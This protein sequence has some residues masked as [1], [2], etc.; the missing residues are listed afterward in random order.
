MFLV[1]LNLCDLLFL[2]KVSVYFGE[3]KKK[4]M[5]R[6]KIYVWEFV[7]IFWINMVREIDVN[8][9]KWMII[10]REF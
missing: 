7:L 4:I 6:L 10:F 1:W 8:V 3:K 5:I 2:V 9:I